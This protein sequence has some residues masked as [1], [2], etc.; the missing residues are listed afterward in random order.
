AAARHLS[1]AKAADELNVSASALSHQ[2]RGLEKILGVKLFE[3]HVRKIELTREGEMLVPGL[4]SGF[5]QIRTS[6]LSLMELENSNILV[7]STP[8]GFTAKWLA[9]R[10]YRFSSLHPD[11]DI[12]IT[13]TSK[14]A[15]F[16]MDGINVAIRNLPLGQESN[17]EITIE[18]LIDIEFIPVCTPEFAMKYGPLDKPSDLIGVPLI[19]DEMLIHLPNTPTWSDW[20]AAAELSNVDVRRGLRFNSSDHALEAAAQGAGILLG[21][22]V[23]AID[24]LDSE[25]LVA[26]IDLSLSPGRA[27][28]VVYPTASSVSTATIAFRDWINLEI[29]SDA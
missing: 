20:F 17:A 16:G 8:P 13:S 26:P 9:P 28:Y 5:A 1:M 11:I 4:Q 29:N 22:N 10:L 19:H 6:L 12:R 25:R 14:I 21:H 27:L 3:R 18:H 23:L 24:D 15:E 2:I 7:V